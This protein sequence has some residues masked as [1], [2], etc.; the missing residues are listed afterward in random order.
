[1]IDSVGLLYFISINKI[2]TVP[3]SEGFDGHFIWRTLY[4]QYWASKKCP[5]ALRTVLGRFLDSSRKNLSFVQEVSTEIFMDSSWT[6]LW[7]DLKSWTL[8]GRP[9]NVLFCWEA[10]AFLTRVT[11][12]NNNEL[13]R[14]VMYV[15][16]YQYRCKLF[17]L[18]YVSTFIVYTIPQ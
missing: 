13:T 1:M 6:F 10:T 18:Q 14:K 15:Q 4:G 7:T 3:I 16:R 12:M 9:K 17:S 5:N 2:D 11:K 8:L